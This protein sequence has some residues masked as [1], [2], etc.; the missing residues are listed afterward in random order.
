MMLGQAFLLAGCLAVSSNLNLNELL[1]RLLIVNFFVFS[2]WLI[3]PFSLTGTELFRLGPLVASQQ[4]VI[5]ALRITLRTNSILLI[6]ISLLSTTSIVALLSALVYFRLPSK[7]IYLFFFLYRYLQVIKEEYHKLYNSLLLRGFRP[8]LSLHV[9]KSYAYL[10]GMLVVKSY[11][12]AQEVY[13]AMLCRGFRG[14]FHFQGE[15]QF[16]GFDLLVA[17]VSLVLFSWLII[18]DRGCWL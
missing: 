1:Q 12:R 11:D 16:A 4:G 9:Y 17:I 5:A 14:R 10:I 18:I 15:F 13:D 6:M 7:L 3:L 8:S 2:I